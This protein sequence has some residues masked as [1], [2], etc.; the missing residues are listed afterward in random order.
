M[1][2]RKVRVFANCLKCGAKMFIGPSGMLH[3][4]ANPDGIVCPMRM[5]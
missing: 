5:W 2:K 3:C 4:S 1:T